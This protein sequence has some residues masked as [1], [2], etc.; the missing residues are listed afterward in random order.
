MT[1]ELIKLNED[2]Q[3][4]FKPAQVDFSGY[5]AMKSQIASLHDSLDGYQVTEDNLKEAK[6]TKSKLNKLKKAINKRKIEI[7]KEMTKPANEFNDKIKTLLN[8]IDDSY[9]AINQQVDHFSNLE[10]EEK[11]EANLKLIEQMSSDAGIDVKSISYDEKWDNK[12]TSKVAIKKAVEV[13]IA[14][15]KRDEQHKLENVQLVAQKANKLGMPQ[16]HWIKELETKPITEVLDAMVQYHDQLKEISKSQ[17]NSKI[18]LI[19]NLKKQNDVFVDPET[20]EIKDKVYT[21]GL[22]LEGTKWQMQQLHSFLKDN[23]IS[24]SR[25]EASHE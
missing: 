1:R 20:G 25:L 23:G 14:V 22:K 8:E 15:I 2:F 4:K 17:K 6:D 5:E 11:H 13:Q 10:K 21:V 12:S 24:Y 9:Q 19:K 16:D 7:K 18:E 3:V